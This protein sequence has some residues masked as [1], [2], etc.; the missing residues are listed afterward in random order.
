M[1]SSSFEFW[2]F[3]NGCSLFQPNFHH[4]NRFFSH[5]YQF[6][7]VRP[8]ISFQLCYFYKIDNQNS[9]FYTLPY[10]KFTIILCSHTPPRKKSL[11]FLTAKCEVPLTQPRSERLYLSIVREKNAKNIFLSKSS[12]K[13]ILTTST[14]HQTLGY[15]NSISNLMIPEVSLIFVTQK[16][17]R[18]RT[19]LQK[20]TF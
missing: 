19:T 2:E 14:L 7:M 1:F 16:F 11:S 17:K 15:V 9:W 13:H 18:E 10:L 12:S 8:E 6:C 20:W 3:S 4:H 5:S